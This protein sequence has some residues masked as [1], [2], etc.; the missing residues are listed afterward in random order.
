MLLYML[1]RI[2]SLL[3]PLKDGIGEISILHLIP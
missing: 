1:P 3:E 2:L